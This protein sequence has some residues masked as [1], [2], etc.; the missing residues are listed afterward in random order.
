MKLEFR[1]FVSAQQVCDWINKHPMY[2]ILS[3]TEFRSYTVFYY[4]LTKL[5]A[6][7]QVAHASCDPGFSIP[8]MSTVQCP[9]FTATCTAFN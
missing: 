5:S 4:D 2:Q 6:D 7:F 3:I 9:P 8:E 1:N